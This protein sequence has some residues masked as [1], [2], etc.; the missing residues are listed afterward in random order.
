MPAV[1]AHQRLSQAAL[2]WNCHT[3]SPKALLKS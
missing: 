1:F 2:G 3:L